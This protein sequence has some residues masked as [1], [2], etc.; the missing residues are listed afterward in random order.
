[1]KIARFWWEAYLVYCDT[2]WYSVVNRVF[3]DL[4]A[5]LNMRV[6]HTHMT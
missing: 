3:V 5:T 4:V 6:L 1:M 2:P